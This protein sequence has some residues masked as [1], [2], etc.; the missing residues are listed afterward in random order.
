MERQHRLKVVTAFGLVYL[1]WGSTY[2]AIRISVE[3]IPPFVMGTVRFLIAG[4]LML[5]YLALTGRKIRLHWSEAWKL[6][7]IGC[8]LLTVG[9]MGVAWAEVYVPSS[10]AALIV[11]VVPIWVAILEAWVFRSRRMAPVGVLGL[12]LGIAGMLVLLWPRLAANTRVGNLELL[13][14]GILVVGSLGW[15]LGSVLA[16]RWSLST[17]VLTAAAWEM[18]FAGLMNALIALFTRSF[19]RA[20][21]TP[22]GSLA[23]FYLI[24]CGSWIGFT[25]YVWLLE[26]VPTPKVATYAYVNPVVAVYLGWLV[27]KEKVDIYMLAG[28]VVILAAVAMVNISKLKSLRAV[29]PAGS[30]ALPNC[31]MAGD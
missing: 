18:T 4:L 28:T 11:A 14:F 26:N 27:L 22:R 20:V 8:L 31:E 30:A 16:G 9:N 29:R 13:G 15:A 7:I 5:G 1:L 17:D 19:Q 10:L 12:V 2:L 24:L 23:V 3:H 21:W 25:A 6:A